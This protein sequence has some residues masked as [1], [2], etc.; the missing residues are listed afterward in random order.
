MIKSTNQL[1]ESWTGITDWLSSDSGVCRVVQVSRDVQCV[2]NRNHGDININNN[3]NNL[4]VNEQHLWVLFSMNVCFFL[5]VYS[6]IKIIILRQICKQTLLTNYNCGCIHP[7]PLEF[8]Q[9]FSQ[10]TTGLARTFGWIIF[11][12]FCLCP[13]VC[14]RIWFRHLDLKK[15]TIKVFEMTKLRA[16]PVRCRCVDWHTQAVCVY[17]WQGCDVI[18][19]WFRSH[20]QFVRVYLDVHQS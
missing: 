1:Q 14:V 16:L 12:L 19:L 5:C 13:Q 17:V 4:I 3:N 9:T 20:H 7:I 11:S 18:L 8:S 10:V 2:N 15:K 6:G